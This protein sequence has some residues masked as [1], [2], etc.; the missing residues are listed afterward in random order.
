MEER[1]DVLFL[2][3][4]PFQERYENFYENFLPHFVSDMQIDSFSNPTRKCAK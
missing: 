4:T 1:D 3:L 2:P